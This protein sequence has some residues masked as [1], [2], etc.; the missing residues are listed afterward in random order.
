MK[1]K[2]RCDQCDI[3]KK[4]SDGPCVLKVPYDSFP[5]EFCPYDHRCAFVKWELVRK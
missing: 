3:H 5:P 1:K 4:F 2:Y